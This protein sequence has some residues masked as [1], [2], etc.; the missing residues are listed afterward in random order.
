MIRDHRRT[1][2]DRAFTDRLDSRV[3]N[4]VGLQE[5]RTTVGILG[6]CQDRFGQIVQQGTVPPELVAVDIGVG[7]Q[8]L[9]GR[10]ERIVGRGARARDVDRLGRIRDGRT[11]R[12]GRLIEDS[13]IELHR[14]RVAD[15]GPHGVQVACGVRTHD[16]SGG[17]EDRSDRVRHQGL[18]GQ[19]TLGD[20]LH[21]RLRRPLGGDVAG[22]VRNPLA[23]RT[24]RN[25][26][27][28]TSD[29]RGLVDL[30]EVVGGEFRL[31]VTLEHGVAGGCILSHLRFLSGAYD[32]S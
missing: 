22:P 7:V 29:Q 26:T 1:T 24:H 32:S 12:R 6:T 3:R 15:L 25:L 27:A 14:D 23:G 31:Q 28:D 21:A 13:P 19:I 20:R 30:G 5:D 4:R 2:Q 11:E 9:Q 17:N 16:L 18:R 8:Q 10:D